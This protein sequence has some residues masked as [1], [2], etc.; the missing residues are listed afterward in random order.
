MR[1]A[2]RTNMKPQCNK[3]AD[4]RF[5]SKNIFRSFSVL[6]SLIA[7]LAAPAAVRAATLTTIPMQ[8][9]MVMPTVTYSASAGALQVTV[10]PTVPQLTPL[11]I[12]NPADHFAAGDPWYDL[13]DSGRQSLAF[14]R[15]YGFVMGS[16]TD[17]LPVGTAIWLRKLSSSPGLGTY[18]YQS[19][20]PKAFDPIFGTA[21]STNA[22]MWNGMMFHPCFTALPGTNSFTATFEA[23]LMNTNAGVEVAGSSSGAFTLNWTNMP[24]GRPLLNLAQKVVIAWPSTAT[25]YVLQCADTM[26]CSAWTTLTNTPVMLDGQPAMILDM[27]G[28]K[29][30]YRMSLVQ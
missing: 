25:N 23:F 6:A 4:L 14:S 24:D 19:S 27:S 12:S 11:L 15:R 3:Q 28:T 7:G 18:R 22:M 16:S 21:G 2:G 17:S 5:M 26:P 13:L 9:T 1:P 29:K 8:G 10:D 20:V 30:F